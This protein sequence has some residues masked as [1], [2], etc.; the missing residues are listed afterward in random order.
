M[1]TRGHDNSNDV[2]GDTFIMTFFD[3]LVCG[4]HLVFTRM[5]SSIG[6]TRHCES[7]PGI[8]FCLLHYIHGSTLCTNCTGVPRSESKPQSQSQSLPLL[9]PQQLPLP[10]SLVKS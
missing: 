3:L 10:P 7:T 8:V 1:G 9:F 2:A 4:L 5:E 6:C